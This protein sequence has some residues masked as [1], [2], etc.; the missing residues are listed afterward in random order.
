[1][2]NMW[3]LIVVVGIKSMW[4]VRGF[5]NFKFPFMESGLSFAMG[6]ARH[7]IW[8]RWNTIFLVLVAFEC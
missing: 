5:W 3:F 4:M 7:L 1:M 2:G 6:Q 8:D